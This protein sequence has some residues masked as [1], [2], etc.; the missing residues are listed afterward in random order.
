[1][2]RL[3]MD[4]LHISVLVEP[5]VKASGLLADLARA[6]LHHRSGQDRHHL[7]GPGARGQL[8]GLGE[9]EVADDDRGL[10]ADAGGNSGAA[11]PERRAIDD[12]YV[13]AFCSSQIRTS[14]A[15]IVSPKRLDAISLKCSGTAVTSTSCPGR[16]PPARKRE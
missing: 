10:I 12:V 14:S 8:V 9:V 6:D 7:G 15:S 13:G 3:V 16:P 5:V 2:R 1:R 4:P 11:A